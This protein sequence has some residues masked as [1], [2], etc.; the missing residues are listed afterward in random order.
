MM[1]L[2]KIVFLKTNFEILQ[3]VFVAEMIDEWFRLLS[4]NFPKIMVDQ[5]V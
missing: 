3:D 4:F 2:T 5:H 1:F